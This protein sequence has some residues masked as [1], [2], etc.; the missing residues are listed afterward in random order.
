MAHI[1]KLICAVHA[2]EMVISRTGQIIA[3]EHPN[4]HKIKVACDMFTCPE[5][6]EVVARMAE[7][8]I[9]EGYMQRYDLIEASMTAR[10]AS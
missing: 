4:G 5:G 1:P 9:A 3:I 10:F 8:A 7:S 6:P 2:I